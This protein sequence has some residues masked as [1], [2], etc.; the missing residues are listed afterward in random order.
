MRRYVSFVCLGAVLIVCSASSRV[1]ARDWDREYNGVDPT[2]LYGGLWLG[3][4]GDAEFDGDDQFAGELETT[5]GG[6]F[7]V[8]VVVLKHLSL[9]GE[10]RIGASKWIRTGDRTKLIDL[11]FKP[12][13]RFPLGRSPF[14]LYFAVPVGVTIPRLAD[15]GPPGVDGKAGWNLGVGGGVNFWITDF[16][17][18]NVEPMWLVH[19]FKVSSDDGDN[20]YTL[21]QFS[22]FLNAAFA[23]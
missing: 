3:F 12:R 17:G 22:L 6:Q 4:G 23:F 13:L 11:D 2:R 15:G 18:L 14:E 5:L 21:K 10:A 7:G 9:G 20:Y 16:F 8:D 1:Q 19:K